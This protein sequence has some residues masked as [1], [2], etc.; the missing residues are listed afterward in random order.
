[1]KLAGRESGRILPRPSEVLGGQPEPE[2][3]FDLDRDVT[4]EDR[5]WLLSKMKETRGKDLSLFFECAVTL[6]LLNPEK[7]NDLPMGEDDWRILKSLIERYDRTG[8]SHARSQLS[9]TADFEALAVLFPDHRQELPLASIAKTFKVELDPDKYLDP[10]RVTGPIGAAYTLT[11]LDPGH[12]YTDQLPPDITD[13]IQLEIERRRKSQAPGVQ[14]GLIR[15]LNEAKLL[16]P[17]LDAITPDFIQPEIVQLS[18]QLK[19]QRRS[20]SPFFAE[21][22]KILLFLTAERAWLTPDGELKIEPGKRGGKLVGRT[23]LPVRPGV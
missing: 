10:D 21:R 7:R 12:T 5:E 23:P 3:A 15:M 18:K 8:H 17:K 6:L 19:Q 2:L 1:M 14:L 11:L 20:H 13:Q 22:L 4:A 16:F 9:A